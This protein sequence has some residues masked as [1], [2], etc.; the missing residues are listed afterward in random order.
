VAKQ[1]KCDGAG[2]LRQKLHGVR[3]EALLTA[4]DNVLPESELRF[5]ELADNVSQFAWTA[6]AKGWIY[7]YN[8]RWH[9]DA[10]FG[11]GGVRDPDGRARDP[12]SILW[13]GR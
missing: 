6:D 4:T 5:R 8:K 1:S 3:A 11:S 13:S 7:W 10:V 12:D 9:A 2:H